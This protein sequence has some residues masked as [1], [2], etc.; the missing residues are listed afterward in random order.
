[1]I[2]M[3]NGDTVIKVL[4]H[5]VDEMIRKGWKVKVEP[6]HSEPDLIEEDDSEEE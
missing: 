5:K 1:M 4:A 2:E 6:G 3:E